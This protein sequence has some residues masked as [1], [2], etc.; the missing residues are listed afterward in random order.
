[1]T[2]APLS[3]GRH[4][5]L[6]MVSIIILLGGLVIRAL[7]RLRVEAFLS[8]A[9]S[10]LSPQ[11][12][13]ALCT[14]AGNRVGP[15]LEECKRNGSVN[16]LTTI[17][18]R[19]V[20]I[21]NTS[22][23]GD[24]NVQGKLMFGDDRLSA[25]PGPSNRTDPYFLEKKWDGK[26]SSLRLTINDDP[27][28][29]LQIWGDACRQAGGCAGAG[30]ERHRFDA[31]GVATHGGGVRVPGSACMEFGADVPGKE[32]NAG[33]VCYGAWGDKD[34]LD[35]VGA[36]AKL[37]E[38]KVRVRDQLCAGG[39]CMKNTGCMTWNTSKGAQQMC[40]MN[41]GNVAILRNGKQVWASG[42]NK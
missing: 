40:F 12:V 7:D 30:V 11:G 17:E 29:S 34:A 35:V 14:S 33:R 18:G 41:D 39:L 24:A 6:A 8:A 19:N 1:M 22:F 5:P 15:L 38:R 36:G 9:T 26:S 42:T 28:E 37:G 10:G 27:D 3:S 23:R 20:M 31:R 21:G 16:G 13:A 25:T 4:A 32:A 2:A